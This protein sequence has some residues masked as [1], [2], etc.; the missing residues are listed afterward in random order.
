MRTRGE[1]PIMKHLRLSR[2]FHLPSSFE[3]SAPLVRLL[4]KSR[5]RCK[6]IIPK[7]PPTR[8]IHRAVSNFC[9]HTD[10]MILTKIP[11]LPHKGAKKRP[12]KKD[13]NRTRNAMCP[14]QRKSAGFASPTP[15][16][17]H[18]STPAKPGR[19]LRLDKP[20]K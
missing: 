19:H 16:G 18:L 14:S 11:N 1:A 4:Q 17:A 13:G 7:L 12:E 9:A 10:V 6:T 3:P 8:A 20:D 15:P 5:I 2:H